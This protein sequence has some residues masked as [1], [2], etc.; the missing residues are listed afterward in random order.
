MASIVNNITYDGKYAGLYYTT[1]LAKAPSLAT[2]KPLPTVKSKEI[3]TKLT[4][5]GLLQADSC[6]NTS[7][8]TIT[9]DQRTVE[10]CP[11]KIYKEL[12]VEDFEQAYESEQMRPGY[13]AGIP[14]SFSDFLLTAV[15]NQLADDMENIAWN[16]NT[17]LTSGVTSLCDGFLTLFGTTGSGVVS[18]SGAT[19]LTSSNIMAQMANAYAAIPGAVLFGSEKPK[20][21]MGTVAA[22]LLSA[23]VAANQ[24][25]QYGNYIEAPV[26]QYLG[27]EVVVS[28]RMPANNIVI[29]Q[30]SNLWYAFDVASENTTVNIADAFVA[31]K[32][33]RKASI[34]GYFKVGFQ[35]AVGAEIVWYRP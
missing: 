13:G 21:Y 11:M 20:I 6:D 22:A 12:C 8:G 24:N 28:N 4:L 1:A 2:F 23:A 14:A 26:L 10:V 34:Y 16:G 15:Q 9:M 32:F 35:F 17:G 19:A 27:L 18:V 3:V 31:P 30:P 29:A 25:V 5:S 33:E 7:T